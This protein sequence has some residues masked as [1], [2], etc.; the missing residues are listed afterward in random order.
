MEALSPSLGRGTSKVPFE[1]VPWIGGG[2]ELVG[3]ST[4][5]VIVTGASIV[6]VATSIRRELL[7][8]LLDKFPSAVV[9]RVEPG[10]LAAVVVAKRP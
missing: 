2:E 7:L 1:N 5:G 8:E 6:G 3:D 10:P 4:I 9:G